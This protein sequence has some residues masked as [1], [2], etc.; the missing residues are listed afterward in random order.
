M[1]LRLP[2]SK[3]ASAAGVAIFV[4]ATAAAQDYR[5]L[6]ARGLELLK[7]GNY[8]E[9]I[10]IYSG[11]L[12]KM[13]DNAVV[14]TNLAAAYYYRAYR[15][16][17]QSNLVGAVENGR[18]A[19][20][21][22]SAAPLIR[23]NYSVCCNNLAMEYASGGKTAEAMSLF[24]EALAATPDNSRVRTNMVGVLINAAARAVR[25]GNNADA[26]KLME[27]AVAIDPS[28]YT[29]YKL[30]GDA[31]YNLDN[32]QMAV[33]CLEKARRISSGEVEAA[34]VTNRI[35]TV[36][37]E[38]VVQQNFQTAQRSHFAVKY[39][40]EQREDLAWKAI[41]MLENSYREVGQ[42]LDC[43]PEGS[44]TVIIYT[45]DQFKSAIAGSEWIAGRYDGKVR[46]S[47]RDLSGA[48]PELRHTLSHEYAHAVLFSKFGAQLPLW[49]NEGIAESVSRD[50]AY[51]AKNREYAAEYVI[52]D[53][54]APWDSDGHFASTNP[55]VVMFA[56]DRAAW[57]A[58]YMFDRYGRSTTLKFA[59]NL[60][61]GKTIQVTCREM[62]N[63][64]PA[65]LIENWK[66]VLR[67]RYP[68]KP[69]EDKN[70]RPGGPGT[71]PR[72]LH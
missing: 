41:E 37:R 15:C 47:V 7:A 63:M 3:L 51:K 4:C 54:V 2:I 50:E 70:R 27:E 6:Q 18:E 40:G 62:F 21:L 61:S 17:M 57:F 9:A 68:P 25:A 1:Y 8:D 11:I 30:M 38:A 56:Y 60:A 49:I 45:A 59:G 64:T 48:G 10:S 65:E 39:E 32:S 33:K 71:Q 55:A 19:F 5:D 72:G 16:V 23:T 22:D 67:Q 36:E 31:Y 53:R 69:K 29:A 26:I 58:D 13:P 20:K 44:V 42:A 66:A 14:R 46:V 28:N 35:A 34:A 52:T 12:G 43:W 24:R